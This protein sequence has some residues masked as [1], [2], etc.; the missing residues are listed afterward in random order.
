[1][2][3][4]FVAGVMNLAWIAALTLI[5]LAEK[6]LPFGERVSQLLGAAAVLVGAWLLLQP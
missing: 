1:M 2:A 6:A 4:L 3:A 5:V